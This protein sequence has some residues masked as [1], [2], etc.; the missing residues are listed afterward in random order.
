MLALAL[1]LLTGG[2]FETLAAALDEQAGCVDGDGGACGDCS[3][4]CS[5]CFCCPARAAPATV[6]QDL[7]VVGIWT[8]PGD[9]P[10]VL[11]TEL[12]PP[13]IFQPPRA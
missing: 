5:A 4:G 7:A 13:D 11:V 2:V 8:E 3:P 10:T 12:V 9:V 6:V 1:A